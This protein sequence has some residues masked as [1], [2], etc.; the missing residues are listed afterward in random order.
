MD[1]FI[2]IHC[3]FYQPP[4]ENPWLEAIESQDSASPYHDWNE[5]ITA[6]CYRPNGA[7]RI[8]DAQGRIRKIVNNYAQISFN[9]GPTLLSW[10]EAHA[11]RAYER[12]LQADRESQPLFSG[13]GGALAQAFNHIILPL[14]NSRD[15]HTQI[16][17]GIRDFQ[18]RFRR[19]PEGMWLPETAVDVE[20]LDI[21]SSLGIKFTILAPH[22]AGRIRKN[23]SAAWT[24]LAGDKIDTSRPYNCSLPSGRTISLFFYNGQISRAIAFERLLADGENFARRLLGSFDQSRPEPQLLHIATDGET[25]GHHHTH[26]DM[27]LAYALDSIQRNAHAQ[28]TNYGEYLAKHPPSQEVEIREKTSWSCAHGVSRWESDCG[29]NSGG[30]GHWTQQWRRPLRDA[31]DW[32]RDDLAGVYEP[33]AQELLRDP[34]TARNEYITVMLDRSPS[35]V[36]SFLTRHAT[37]ELSAQDQVQALRLLEM[38]RHLMLMYTSC[39]WFFDE[40]T[41]PETVQIL[42]YAGRA[43]QLGESLIGEAREELFLQKLEKLSSNIPGFGNGRD[44][45]E[46]FVRAAMLDLLGVAAHYAISSL[47]DGYHQRNSIYSY[48][49]DLQEVEVLESGK[50]KLALGRARLLSRITHGRLSF[51]FATLYVGDKLC[52]GI[53]ASHGGSGFQTF[54]REASLAFS[55][56]DFAQCLQ[57]LDHYFQ[58]A[59]YSLNSLF[60]DE[61]QRI[62]TQ[63]V[64]STLGDLD[65][66]YQQV[67]EQ[68]APLIRFLA[69]FQ[70]PL[71]TILRV[72]AEFVLGNAVRRCVAAEDL[73]LSRV[74]KLL[75]SAAQQGITIDPRSLESALRVQ[76][77]RLIERCAQSAA[78]PES[79]QTLEALVSFARVLPFKV[80]LWN[81]QNVYYELLRGLSS[82]PHLPRG[83]GWL[84]HFRGLGGS[85]GIALPQN[86]PE[87]PCAPQEE[88][89]ALTANS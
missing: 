45:Y 19:D 57:I 65:A 37:R 64:N 15:K 48:R 56:S 75:A 26:G 51:T 54:M 43:V 73:D 87:L 41:G 63:I 28:L 11:P 53:R 84:D 72:S 3:H 24:E 61:K 6:E 17:W 4:R 22:Q 10:M 42:Q 55:K 30:Y 18:H 49:V 71:P 34:W 2:C 79:L 89:I 81:P 7:A 16:Y 67:Y 31:L 21:L 78:S 5:R 32:L 69:E 74:R 59:T 68:H 38:Q 12:I 40:P 58:G 9:F 33:C 60:R 50:A 20:T 62:V 77:N 82:Q 35:N 1:R 85:L 88:T 66:I 46:R 25:Y 70:M 47:F 29:C 27:A 86:F 13:H 44:I 14:A 8:L 52:T 23:S 39:G 83:N 36:E 80:D 76:L